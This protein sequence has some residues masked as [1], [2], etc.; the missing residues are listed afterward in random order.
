MVVAV[1][2][3]VLT[4]EVVCGFV[5]LNKPMWSPY[6]PLPPCTK[7]VYTGGGPLILVSFDTRGGIED[8]CWLSCEVFL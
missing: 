4:I 7:W 2:D 6:G 3:F 8:E 5:C 1:S